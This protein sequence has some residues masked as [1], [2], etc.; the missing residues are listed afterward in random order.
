VSLDA[1]QRSAMRLRGRSYMAFT[2]SPEPPIADWLG[3]LDLWIKSSAGFFVGR[4]VVLD[5]AK[6]T[7]TAPAV[8]HLLS[9]L[10]S[11]D[12][13]VMGL[14][15]IDP[16]LIGPGM[17][18]ILSGGRTVPVHMTK[19]A[20]A[21]AKEA[22]SPDPKGSEHKGSEH[23]DATPKNAASDDT[24]TPVSA[25]RDAAE[26][27]APRND[28]DAQD[29][30]LPFEAPLTSSS[31]VL[32][33]VI[34]SGQSIFHPNGDVIVIGSVASGA[35]V[36]A[37]GSIHIYGTLRG[38]AMAGAS[39]N[40]NARIF[41]TRIAAELLAIDGYYRTAED[42]DASLRHRPVQAWLEDDTLKVAALD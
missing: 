24:A 9:E 23:E 17:P 15:G 32:D 8:T 29:M 36:V 21:R 42:L 34:R 25:T 12:I 14:E 20:E 27:A 38:R 7:L 26:G 18:P 41:C 5:L 28:G 3:E 22:A 37:S 6:V 16:E 1:N 10:R 4:P 30:S 31:L 35:E 39:G 11:R 33:R 19:Q 2:L 13:R 40:P